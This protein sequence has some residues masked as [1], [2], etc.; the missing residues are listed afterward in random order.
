M[1]VSL[2]SSQYQPNQNGILARIGELLL[3]GLPIVVVGSIVMI[4]AVNLPYWDDFIVQ[5]HLL[6]L[7]NSS[8]REKLA[9]IF[10]QHWEHRIVWTRLIFATYAE[11]NGSLNYYNLTLIGISGLLAVLG[12]LF[13]EF[14]R[15]EL[16][17]IY[18]APLPFLLLTL[19][20]YENLIWAM[21][22]IQN[23]WVLVFAL[24]SFYWLAHNTP[25]TRIVA[26]GLG[27]WATFTSGN[28]PLVLIAGLF[29]LAYQGH[30]RS[31]LIWALTTAASLAGYFYNYKPV[32]FFPS[33]FKYPFIDWIKAFFVFLGG[34]ADPAINSKSE[35]ITLW[36][37]VVIGVIIGFAICRFLVALFETTSKT[38]EHSIDSFFL[39]CALFLLATAVTTVYHRVGFGGPSYLL[40]S[41]YKI[42]SALILSV[43]Y[44]YSLYRW[45]LKSFL[46]RFALAVL[47]VCICQNFLS[48]Y[49]GLEGLINQHR[50]TT[51]E[52]FGYVANTSPDK[53]QASRQVF[54][55][56]NPPF[57]MRNVGQLSN[58]GWLSTP[59]STDV[60]GVDEQ[61]F[62]CN[63]PKAEALNPTLTLPDE[64]SYIFLKDSTY[65]YLFAAQP[66]RNPFGSRRYYR[67][68]GFFAQ[69]LKEKLKPG[70]YRIGVL[71]HQNKRIHL[72]MTNRYI[73]F[74][75]L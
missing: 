72:A 24:G 20:S 3:I 15:L 12:I 50:R 75:S 60:D 41:R 62:I 42:Y 63:I 39:G 71:T 45:K 66:V 68:S 64:G 6:M 4:Y 10:D 47:I 48:N 28:G 70:H 14:R 38:N 13:A 9:H 69:V 17:L 53:L 51:A 52:Y 5:E 22:S 27:L 7:K 36:L 16:P 34:F 61:P 43:V 44:L 8:G 33:P 49:F 73:T 56:T 54:T 23:F 26:F 25:L 58:N 40:Q 74:V 1:S 21:A 46:L 37:A 18:F 67:S 2:P 32:T 29:V 55:P 57:F 30:W 59:A 11:I 65:T 19:Q 35:G 31:V